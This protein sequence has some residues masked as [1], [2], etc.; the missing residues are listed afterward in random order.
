MVQC[1]SCKKVGLHFVENI[2]HEWSGSIH[3]CLHGS[4]RRGKKF[5]DNGL[6]YDYIEDGYEP[7]TTIPRQVRLEG[8]TWTLYHYGKVYKVRKRNNRK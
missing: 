4:K 1:N 6:E 5:M 2:L 7:D 3:E 8:N